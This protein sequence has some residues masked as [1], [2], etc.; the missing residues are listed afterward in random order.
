MLLWGFLFFAFFAVPAH[1]WG[2]WFLIG[3]PVRGVLGMI[4]LK[5]LPNTHDIVQ[6]IDISDIPQEEISVEK[7]TEKIKFDLSVQFMVKS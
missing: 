6:D 1:L 3:H 5:N 4:L 2:V 7:L